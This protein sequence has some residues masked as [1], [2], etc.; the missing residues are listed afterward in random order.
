MS[1]QCPP[2]GGDLRVQGCSRGSSGARKY[3]SSHGQAA[4][5]AGAGRVLGGQGW[6][7]PEDTVALKVPEGQA[8]EGHTK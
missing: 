8:G 7:S 1:P 5:A 2:S 4:A 6:Q 3:P